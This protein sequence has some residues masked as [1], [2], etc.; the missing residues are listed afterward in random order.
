MNGDGSLLGTLNIKQNTWK[1][2]ED[3]IFKLSNS[4]QFT[5]SNYILL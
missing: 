2:N 3:F 5:G 1:L 4:D